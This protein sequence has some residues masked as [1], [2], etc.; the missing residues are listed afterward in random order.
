MPESPNNPNPDQPPLTVG[1]QEIER[2]LQQAESLTHEIVEGVGAKASPDAATGNPAGQL[3]DA[4]PD[5][6]AAVEL[7]TQDVAQL[8]AEVNE[9]AD[10]APGAESVEDASENAEDVGSLTANEPETADSV[11]AVDQD[12]EATDDDAAIESSEANSADALSQIESGESEEAPPA[13]S[14]IELV[15][16]EAVAAPPEAQ[17]DS[18]STNLVPPR[19]TLGGLIKHGAIYM[20]RTVV[21]AVPNI[22]IRL[23]MLLDWP[24]RGI[25]PGVKNALGAIGLISMM[26]GGVAMFAPSM[27]KHNPYAAMPP[28]PQKAEPKEAAKP[29]E[30]AAKHGSAPSS[31]HGGH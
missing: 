9:S 8:V 20:A 26:M 16:T 17:A 10:A 3:G 28:F 12:V 25:S 24:F 19:R 11:A 13:V 30:P 15:A 4:E 18:A 7:V 23:L 29:S 1:D 31:G 5:A 21:F 2:L 22:C 27:M 14:A 6:E